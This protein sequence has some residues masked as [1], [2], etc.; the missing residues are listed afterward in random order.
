[1]SKGFLESPMGPLEITAECGKIT[2]IELVHGMDEFV[3]D[4]RNEA[5]E[6]IIKSAKKQLTEYFDGSRQ[7]FD[8][9]IDLRG[10]EFQKS[11]WQVLMEIP[12]GRTMSYAEVAAAAGRPKAQRAAG[13][14]I[15]KNPLL[16]VVPCHRV[17]SADGSLGGFSAGI[18]NKVILHRIENINLKKER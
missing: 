16:I 15:G 1:M 7:T 11:V 18:E 10:T 13:S 3:E 5:D 17:I 9:D 12:Y 2:K 6:Q 14:N 4:C 8:L